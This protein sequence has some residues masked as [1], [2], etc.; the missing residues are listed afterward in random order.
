MG[1]D[2]FGAGKSRLGRLLLGIMCTVVVLRRPEHDWPLIIGA[3]RDEM[4]E[5]P[6]LA[7]A[8]HWP[9][10]THVTAGMDELAGGTWLAM[11][12]DGV[13]A[14]ILN[15]QNSLG[16]ADNKRSRGELPLEAV[17]HAEAKEAAKA[18]AGLD[19]TSYRSF[20]LVIADAK[21]A[22]WLRSSGA[23]D[24]SIEV[25]E[26]PIGISM[27]T[28]QD[29][30][31]VASPRIQTHLSRFRNAPPP[32]P[33][34]DDWFTWQGLLSTRSSNSDAPD[35]AAMNITTMGAFG[36]VCSSLIALPAHGQVGVKAKWQF[37][38]GRP[39]ENPFQPV[40]F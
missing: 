10:R 12:D 3:N 2:F 23:A 28:A 35:R 16:P 18:L 17:D 1:V 32:D 29:L 9:D 7:P 14:S 21:H 4:I 40:E 39:D 26:I 20:N 22:F 15:R 31:D 36:T 27:I 33:G 8:R 30:N 11:N 37:C 5:R 25:M 13:V 6:W 24:S 34:T 19:P 38:G